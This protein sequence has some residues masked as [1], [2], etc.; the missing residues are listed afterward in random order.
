MEEKPIPLGQV[1]ALLKIREE[2]GINYVQRVTAQ[3]A[4]KLSRDAVYSEEVIKTLEDE[5]E[6][7]RI[8]VV[9]IVNLNPK[10]PVD[11]RAVTGNLLSDDQI[12]RLLT[13]YSE[14]VVTLKPSVEEDEESKDEVEE[15]EEGFEDL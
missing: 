5:F 15:I 6:L 10:T 12:E 8:L 13:R 14:F 9:Q 7:P 11:I 1:Y 4:E 3:H 2:T